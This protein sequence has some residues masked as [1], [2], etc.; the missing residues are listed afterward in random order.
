M[1]K[2]PAKTDKGTRKQ[3]S[4]QIVPFAA[5][6]PFLNSVHLRFIRLVESQTKIDVKDGKLPTEIKI[7]LKAGHALRQDGELRVVGVHVQLMIDGQTP[8]GGDA[9][10]DAQCSRMTIS[11]HFECQYGTAM[12]PNDD[13]LRALDTIGTMAVWPVARDFVLS[14][15]ARM[16]MVPT[17]LPSVY[18]D[19]ETRQIRFNQ[20]SDSP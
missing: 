20:V 4:G 6:V 8:G 13:D 2:K 3:K 7:D 15:S 1:K 16:G 11:A 18:V 5:S 10:A 14:L 9:D 17:L 12:T 19:K